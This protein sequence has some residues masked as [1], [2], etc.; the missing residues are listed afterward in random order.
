MVSGLDE[1]TK[2]E[3]I[4]KQVTTITIQLDEEKNSNKEQLGK[5]D[6][7]DWSG[8]TEMTGERSK[9]KEK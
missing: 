7:T 1:L 6:K 2:R 4:K 9:S 3:K 5:T 8:T